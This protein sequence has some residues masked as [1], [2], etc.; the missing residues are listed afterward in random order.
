MTQQDLLLS[1]AELEAIMEQRRGEEDEGF[2]DDSL[3][4]PL[5]PGDDEYLAEPS[6]DLLQ[7]A[8]SV[9]GDNF[10]PDLRP[11]EYKLLADAV[12]TSQ[13][14]PPPPPQQQ[15]A[16]KQK[17]IELE[18]VF[19]H[20]KSAFPIVA[21]FANAETDRTRLD[22]LTRIFLQRMLAMALVTAL[23][24]EAAKQRES[25]LTG[26]SVRDFFVRL[27][28]KVLKGGYGEVYERVKG[29]LTSIWHAPNLG[30]E[31][32]ESEKEYAQRRAKLTPAETQAEL[33]L[34]Q[35]LVMQAFPMPD[36][37]QHTHGYYAQTIQQYVSS[38][39]F[40]PILE[41]ARQNELVLPRHVDGGGMTSYSSG[42]PP[43]K[44]RYSTAEHDAMTARI[45]A[46]KMERLQNE[47]GVVKNENKSLRA[48]NRVSREF[49][50]DP[51]MKRCMRQ[52]KALSAVNKQLEKT[53]VPEFLTKSQELRHAERLVSE[54]DRKRTGREKPVYPQDMANKTCVN[55]MDHTPD[56]LNRAGYPFHIGFNI[57][58]TPK[59]GL[60]TTDDAADT[61][62]DD[63]LDMEREP[64][65][66][67]FSLSHPNFI[68]ANTRSLF[69]RSADSCSRRSKA[70]PWT[71]PSAGPAT[72][73][74]CRSTR[75][76][77]F[78]APTPTPRR[79]TPRTGTP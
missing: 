71:A 55:L 16:G 52:S 68:F 74:T 11:E 35:S 37:T 2:G 45:A 5:P 38:G 40:A 48:E 46:E 43:K 25:R 51:L 54:N 77:A 26:A 20:P 14:P 31:A 8:T 9:L 75:T 18:R 73:R 60:D 76:T 19:P 3:L 6:Q 62:W 7:Q 24:Q 50:I 72:P 34:V 69:C 28:Q 49:L 42:T 29:Q 17:F 33:E 32:A 36:Q 15:E 47:L 27:I 63:T 65:S 10:T 39:F 44:R 67:K 70:M 12:G 59:T 30:E 13:P 1:N 23:R 57:V 22:Y 61:V 79:T 53:N 78:G 4:P 58:H 41:K 64:V 66:D 21:D 56:Q